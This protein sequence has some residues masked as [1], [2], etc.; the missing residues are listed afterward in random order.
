LIPEYV[1]GD[2]FRVFSSL[3]IPLGDGLAGWVAQNCKPILNGNPAVES[4]Y[5][6]GKHEEGGMRSALAVPLLRTD[7]E[8]LGVLAL[9]NREAD[10]FSNDHLRIL[11]AITDKI[12]ASIDNALKY[13]VAAD[14]AKVDYLT[15]LPNARSLFIHLDVEIARCCRERGRLAAIV[16][17]LNGFKALNDRFGHVAGNKVLEVF[18]GKL[19]LVCRE[20]D[21]ISRMGGDEFVL[22]TPGMGRRSADEVC[23]RVDLAASESA[24]EVCPG[25]TLSASVGAAFFPEDAKDAEQLLVEADKRMYA[26]KKLKRSSPDPDNVE[27]LTA[28][29]Q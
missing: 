4:G 19:R 12:A 3:E 26:D 5:S 22:I 24:R 28:V 27:L 29:V 21:F 11:L 7:E 10:A 1:A 25:G 13:Q 23:R 20:Y 6:G 18:A 8:S 14:S 15:G 9:Y 2:E 16:C 17:D